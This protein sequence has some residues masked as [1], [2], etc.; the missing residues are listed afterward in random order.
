MPMTPEDMTRARKLL[1][2]TQMQ[3]ADALGVSRRAVVSWE[4]DERPILRT[5]ELARKALLCQQRK[6]QP[7][8]KRARG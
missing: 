6:P 4:H 1:G 7:P 3:L 5:V 2:M 8:R